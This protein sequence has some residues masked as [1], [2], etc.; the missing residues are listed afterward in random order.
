[1]VARSSARAAGWSFSL[2]VM[3]PA[4]SWSN[5]RTVV[6][7]LRFQGLA[8][9]RRL[10]RNVDT[11]SASARARCARNMPMVVPAMPPRMAGTTS[12]PATTR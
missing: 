4:A 5:S 8:E 1:M 11:A 7:F 6:S 3:R 12:V 2:F 10:V 9:S